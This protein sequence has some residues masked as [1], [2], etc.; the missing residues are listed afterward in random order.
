MYIVECADHSYYTGCALDLE[1]RI[2]THNKAKGAKYTRG[3]L[4]VRLRYS[5]Y[6][7]TMGEALSREKQVQSLSRDKKESL[8]IKK[9][10][11]KTI[12]TER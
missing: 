8:F 4:P 5:E 1:K 9:K 7:E 10:K 12:K 3:R 11:P 2:E 6:F